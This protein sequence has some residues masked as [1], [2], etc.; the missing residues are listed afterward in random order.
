MKVWESSLR[1]SSC[2]ASLDD[3]HV[4]AEVRNSEVNDRNKV[5]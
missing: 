1:I 4:S 5:G 2:L 3:S